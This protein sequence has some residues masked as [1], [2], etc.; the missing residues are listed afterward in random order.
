MKIQ[1]L[2]SD[3]PTTGLKRR[4]TVTQIQYIHF[5]TGE[6][7]LKTKVEYGTVS[8]GKAQ[9]IPDL[10]KTVWIEISNTNKITASGQIIDRDYALTQTA[11]SPSDDRYDAESPN[12]VEGADYEQEIE[13][14]LQA[15]LDAGFN[16]F[17]RWWQFVDSQT[18][19]DGLENTLTIFD[20]LGKFN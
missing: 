8:G 10:E 1:K 20:Q 2:I 6:M 12:Y 5:E 17:D 7:K 3:D 18:I 4:A 19:E 14:E 13:A 16:Q 9:I 15:L 11:L